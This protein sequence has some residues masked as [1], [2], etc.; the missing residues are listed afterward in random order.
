[1]S[2]APASAVSLYEAVGGADRLRA[3]VHR[4]VVE[5]DTLPSARPL[6]RLFAAD[7]RLHEQ[8]LFEFLSG[9]LGG[10]ALYTQRHGLP[11]LRARHRH[12]PIGNA[13]RDQWLLCMRRALATEVP[14]AELRTRLDAAFWTMACSLRNRDGAPA[15]D[16]GVASPVARPST[17]ERPRGEST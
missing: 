1:M 4:F 15:A 17:I 14:A 7:L 2:D 13:E 3:I 10:P 11:N 6:R 16:L 5:L 12:L 9:W 8:R